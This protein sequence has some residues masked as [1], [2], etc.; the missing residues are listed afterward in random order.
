MSPDDRD[1]T[2]QIISEEEY[3]QDMKK[4]VDNMKSFALLS[5]KEKKNLYSLIEKGD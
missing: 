2:L 4:K 5:N 1:P 3:F